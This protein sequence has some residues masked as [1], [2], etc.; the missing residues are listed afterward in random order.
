MAAS[1][2]SLRSCKRVA[3]SLGQCFS[4]RGLF[5]RDTPSAAARNQFRSGSLGPGL[6]GRRHRIEAKSSM[7]YA[8]TYS[9]PWDQP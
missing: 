7:T 9:L 4:D 1:P 2:I 6:Q 8:K 5:I 3:G